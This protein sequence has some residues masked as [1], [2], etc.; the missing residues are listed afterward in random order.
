M[1][2]GQGVGA[3]DAVRALR[4][5]VATGLTRPKQTD[6]SLAS[7]P[8]RT[9]PRGAAA[10]CRALQQSGAVDEIATAPRLFSVV[11]EARLT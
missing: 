5:H 1:Y 7:T 8:A 10:R 2:A 3:I 4:P 9:S 6:R 11:R